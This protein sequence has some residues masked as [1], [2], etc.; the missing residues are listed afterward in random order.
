[1]S[2]SEGLADPLVRFECAKVLVSRGTDGFRQAKARQP[3]LRNSM[4]VGDDLLDPVG[5]GS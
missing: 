5:T 2:H 1:M 3:L 4:N